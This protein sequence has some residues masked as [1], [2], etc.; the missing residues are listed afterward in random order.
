VKRGQLVGTKLALV[1]AHVAD[2]AGE[3]P[4]AGV[5]DVVV[6]AAEGKRG[7][8]R[9]GQRFGSALPGRLELA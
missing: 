3:K 6:V 2:A 5:A 7:L 4:F 9:G 8:G 1:D